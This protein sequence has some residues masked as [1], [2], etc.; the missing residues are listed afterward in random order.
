[1][2]NYSLISSPIKSASPFCSFLNPLIINITLFNELFPSECDK[3]TNTNNITSFTLFIPSPSSYK[4][5][6][7]HT[8]NELF[9][10]ISER[11]K[12]TNATTNIS[13]SKSISY[14]D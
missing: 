12:S 14:S 11:D 7:A 8:F 5:P 4:T 9:T 10:G 3:S 1:M 2:L 6:F 13:N